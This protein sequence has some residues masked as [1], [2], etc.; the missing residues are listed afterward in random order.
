MTYTR[1]KNGGICFDYQI[2]LISLETV[3]EMNHLGIW[4]DPKMLAKMAFIE[5]TDRL[6]AK[7][8]GMLG[9]V[10]RRS[11]EF[12]NSHAVKTLSCWRLCEINLGIFVRIME[13][14]LEIQT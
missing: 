10:I 12:N 1:S 8:Y 2:E 7:A 4:F 6:I 9:L 11:R 5:N 3:N 13:K 14:V